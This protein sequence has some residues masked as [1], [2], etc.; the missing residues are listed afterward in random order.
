[1][2]NTDNFISGSVDEQQTKMYRFSLSSIDTFEEN[3]EQMDKAHKIMTVISLMN[4]PKPT[5]HNNLV[6]YYTNFL[7]FSDKELV[8][9]KDN[10]LSKILN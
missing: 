2:L 5:S 3:W 1:M 10:G 7:F 4:H 6:E 8:K 9:L